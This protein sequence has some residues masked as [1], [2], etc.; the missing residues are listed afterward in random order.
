MNVIHESYC[1][2]DIDSR[3]VINANQLMI[4]KVKKADTQMLQCNASN[5]HGYLLANAYLNVQ[6]KSSVRYVNRNELSHLTM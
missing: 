3:I 4:M 2:V 5:V 1:T 6:G